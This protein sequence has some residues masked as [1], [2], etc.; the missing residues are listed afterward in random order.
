MCHEFVKLVEED[1]PQVLVMLDKGYGLSPAFS[2]SLGSSAK[3]FLLTCLHESVC[4]LSGTNERAHSSTLIEYLSSYNAT[5]RRAVGVIIC[6]IA[7]DPNVILM[8]SQAPLSLLL[9]IAARV[10]YTR[11]FRAWYDRLH[12]M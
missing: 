11:R 6:T 1:Y 5:C 10:Q 2:R 8:T 12:V 9:M 3:L 7:R 4:P